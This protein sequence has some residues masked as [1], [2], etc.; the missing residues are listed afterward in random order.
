MKDLIKPSPC[1]MKTEKYTVTVE[2]IEVEKETVYTA[3]VDEIKGLIV[4][5][6]SL[7]KVFIELG[8]SIHIK[9]EYGR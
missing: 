1:I 8:L 6:D 4:Q 2:I 9:K 7:P 3:W 5:S